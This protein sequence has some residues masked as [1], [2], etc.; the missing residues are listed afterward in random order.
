MLAVAVCR[1]AAAGCPGGTLLRTDDG[2]FA[3]NTGTGLP[4]E[5]VSVNGALAHGFNHRNKPI[6]REFSLFSEFLSHSEGVV[7]EVDCEH[8]GQVALLALLL[9]RWVE[10]IG[11][12]PGQCG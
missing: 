10:L 12:P 9:G 6:P 1:I 4:F 5:C 3:A 11:N 8:C 2:L 7:G